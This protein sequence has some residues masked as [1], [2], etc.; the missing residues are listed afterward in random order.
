[1]SHRY[2]QCP[3]HKVPRL[4]ARLV[5]TGLWMACWLC[6][7]QAL[8]QTVYRCGNEYSDALTCA[9]ANTALVHDARTEDQHTAQD[10]LTQQTQTQAETLE[11]NRLKAEK[12][13]S[14]AN[15]SIAAWPTQDLSPIQDNKDSGTLDSPSPHAHHKK[16]SPYFTAKDGKPKAKKTAPAKAKQKTSADTPAKP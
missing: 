14:R 7:V 10:R 13:S 12:Q 11:R 5:F 15:P 3:A 9:H 1:M 16:T 4:E 6:D 8:A 2:P